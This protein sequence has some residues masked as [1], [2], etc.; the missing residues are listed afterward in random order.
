MCQ[1]TAGFENMFMS[2][3][4]WFLYAATM[5]I[6]KHYHLNVKDPAT[7]ANSL[8][9]SSYAGSSVSIVDSFV[10]LY[11]FA[12]IG[13]QINS[14][15][16]LMCLCAENAFLQLHYYNNYCI[17]VYHSQIITVQIVMVQTRNIHC[18]HCVKSVRV[19]WVTWWLLP[20]KQWISDVTD[21]KSDIQYSTVQSYHTSVPVCMAKS[22][23]G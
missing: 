20:I 10:L 6:F 2:H 23:S 5:R 21:D 7:A 9:F 3:N 15:V 17:L 13:N 14:N 1:V 18:L 12:C 4:A 19:P 16:I 11:V 8:S 22:P